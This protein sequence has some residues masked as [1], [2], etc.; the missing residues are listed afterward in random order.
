M[1]IDLQSYPTTSEELQ[2]TAK[3]HKFL[4]QIPEKENYRDYQNTK[5]GQK[6]FGQHNPSY[7]TTNEYHDNLTSGSKDFD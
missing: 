3:D 2:P 5:R 1:K 4:M 7:T 6:L